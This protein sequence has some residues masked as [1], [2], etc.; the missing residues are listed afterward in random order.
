MPYVVPS[1]DLQEDVRRFA[2]GLAA[3]LDQAMDPLVN[4][5]DVAV[6]QAALG[7]H[8]KY[9]AS[10]VEIACGPQP[11]VDVLDMYVFVR[12][13][14]AALERHWIPVV[15]GEDGWSVE[16][17]FA[18]SE[19]EIAEVVDKL[20]TPYERRELDGL[21]D[22][23]LSANSDQTSFEAV[24]LS[25]LSE[26][27]GEST[28]EQSRA[29]GLL[30]SVRSAT[31]AADRALLLGERALFLVQTMPFLLRKQARLAGR[32][33]MTDAVRTVRDLVSGRAALRALAV[34]GASLGVGLLM[35][36]LPRHVRLR[37]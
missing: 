2:G 4:A 7:R 26:Q 11:Q 30:A 25:G 21:I 16:H 28:E 37:H 9:L 35:G 1:A 20:M 27:F 36:L 29:R 8:L 6:G 18:I 19:P 5:S 32:E 34:A 12:L 23:F 31:Q 24:R 3:R 13:S 17:A 10:I 22:D 15:F 14:R 33:L